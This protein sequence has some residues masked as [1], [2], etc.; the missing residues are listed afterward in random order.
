MSEETLKDLKAKCLKAKDHLIQSLKKIK[1]GRASVGLLE[2]LGVSYYG[3]NVPL[4]QVAHISVIDARTL[5]VQ[6]YDQGAV[7]EIENS[8][9]NSGLGLNP[10]REGSFL[11]IVLPTMTEE[12]RKELGKKVAQ[13]VEDSKVEIR[14][15]RREALDEIKNSHVSEDD[16]KRFEKEIQ[17]VIDDFEEDFDEILKEKQQELLEI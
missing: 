13:M 15:F 3:A 1:T 8:I 7:A 12:R 9:R 14:R 4:K 5:G 2:D 6:V 16:K 17:K 11:R 10:Q